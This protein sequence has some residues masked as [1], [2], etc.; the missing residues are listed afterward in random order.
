MWNRA[1]IF[2]CVL[3]MISVGTANSFAEPTSIRADA[4]VDF[5]IPAQPL[6]K[7]LLAYGTATGLNIFYNAVLSDGRQSAAVVGRHRPDQALQTLLSGTGYAAKPTGAHA[8]MIA[9]SNEVVA[10]VATG[11]PRRFGP[12]FASLQLTIDDAICRRG[13]AGAGTEALLQL[14]LSPTGTVIKAEEIGEDGRRAVDQS[15]ATFVRGL[16]FAPPPAAMPQPVNM[17]IFPASRAVRG[18]GSIDMQRRAG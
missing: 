14:W 10:P 6:A 9:P 1:T 15:Q 12:Y 8:F 17:V 13:Y 4:Q 11:A 18:C 16:A 7:A 3:T 2:I 5:N